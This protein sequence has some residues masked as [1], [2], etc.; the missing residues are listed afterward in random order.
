MLKE[1]VVFIIALILVVAGVSYLGLTLYRFVNQPNQKQETTQQVGEEG[2]EG[3]SDLEVVG[4]SNKEVLNESA[5][6]G[7]SISISINIKNNSDEEKSINLEGRVYAVSELLAFPNIDSDLPVDV[8]TIPVTISPQETKEVTYDYTITECGN[9]YIALADEDFWS[10]GR[11]LVSYG[12]FSSPCNG[13]T[14]SGSTNVQEPTNQV[15]TTKGGL[16]LYDQKKQ[17]LEQK[18]VLGTTTKGGLPVNGSQP[19]EVTELPKSGTA[20]NVMILLGVLLVA[21]GLIKVKTLA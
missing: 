6:V 1:K 18:K 5:N 14:N 19:T 10:T 8:K 2:S 9:F 12:Y 4:T 13:S 11:G 3:V 7:D 21:L 20:E 17:E 16:T 15:P